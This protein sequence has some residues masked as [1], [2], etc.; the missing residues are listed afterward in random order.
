MLK[1][2]YTRW[3][4]K[5][6]Y[7]FSKISGQQCTFHRVFR[8]IFLTEISTTWKIW[9][10]YKYLSCMKFIWCKH[11]YCEDTTSGEMFIKKS[12]I[13]V[14]MR[15]HFRRKYLPLRQNGPRCNK[16]SFKRLSFIWHVYFCCRVNTVAHTCLQ[17]SILSALFR[18]YSNEHIDYTKNV[19]KVTEVF[20]R[21]LQ[22]VNIAIGIIL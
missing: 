17:D 22:G 11:Y 15:R 10:Y 19:S 3:Q 13:L 7:L 9:P 4:R 2:S 6:R 14:M 5:F 12:A 20:S 8:M 1:N 18:H 16:R 21:I